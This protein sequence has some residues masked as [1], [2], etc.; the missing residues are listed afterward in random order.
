MRE[1]DRRA[2]AVGAAHD[3]AHALA[4][5]GDARQLVGAVVGEGRRLLL[6][7]S[8]A[9]PPRPGCRTGVLRAA[10]VGVAALP[11]YELLAGL[12]L[13]VHDAAPRRHQVDLARPDR[14]RRAQAV[15]VPH[16][17]LEQVGD[18]GEPDVGVRAHVD[19]VADQELG[20]P[21]L[22]EEDEGP[23]HL[24]LRR[25]QRA[26]HLEAAE[27]AGARHDH[28]LD[29]VAGELVAGNGVLAGLPAHVAQSFLVWSCRQLSI[30]RPRLQRRRRA[31]IARI[32]SDAR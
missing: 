14:R 12:A 6:V 19:A 18:G 23:D 1:L 21:H 11:P 22:V 25:G 30:A 7:A 13:G 15:A 16:L 9:A 17:A 24:L 32:G 4:L 2:R 26:A 27:I 28:V 29:G 3:Q 31:D 5:A 20:R 10:I 8:W